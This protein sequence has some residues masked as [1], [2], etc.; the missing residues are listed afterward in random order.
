MYT[1]YKITNLINNKIYVG[2]TVKT[3]NERLQEH[4]KNALV[5]NKDFHLSKAIR[6]YGAEN[7]VTEEID[8]AKTKIIAN[9]KETYWINKL[10]TDKRDIGYNMTKGGDGGNTY[11]VKTEDEMTLIK[12]KISNSNTGGKNGNSH[13]IICKNIITNEILTFGSFTESSKYFSKLYNENINRCG[14]VQIKEAKK[15]NVQSAFK[16]EW[17]FASYGNEFSNYSLSK[18]KKGSY[19]LKVT[20]ISDNKTYYGVSTEDVCNYFNI[21]YNKRVNL[22]KIKEYHVEIL[23]Q[24]RRSRRIKK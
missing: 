3:A 16:G 18:R 13:S 12:Q 22:F 5:F 4:I 19:H 10:K 2:Q 15:Y 1:I 20:R 7:F 6:K 14:E 24:E 21:D 23:G 8:Y 9:Q 11:L 17:I